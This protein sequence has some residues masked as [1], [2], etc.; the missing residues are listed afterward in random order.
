MIAATLIVRDEASQ[1]PEW[2]AYHHAIG[3]GKFVIY[4]HESRD[5]T[6]SVLR[7]SQARFDID[8]VSWPT[9]PGKVTQFFA[10]RDA[11]FRLRTQREVEWCAFIDIDEFLLSTTGNSV[12]ELADRCKHAAAI[13]L[14]WAV[15]GP[16]SHVTGHSQPDGLIIDQF[17]RRAPLQDA[18]NGPVKS[19]VRP[20]AVLDLLNPHAFLVDGQTV[21]GN[22][23]AFTF[24]AAENG[25][26]GPVEL[27]DWRV[28]HYASRGRWH[29]TRRLLRGQL[30]NEARD[31]TRWET[32][33]RN[34]EEDRSAP[35]YL[36]DAV[37]AALRE[38]NHP[39]SDYSILELD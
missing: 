11:C 39:K 17:I 2:L 28:N 15:F 8:V 12:Q 3:I 23:N 9:F 32:W 30:G 6:I 14:H 27:S 1:L 16:A 20:S 19:L 25:S 29:W 7:R 10:Y 24:N 34:E 5:D 36:A 22:G 13:T 33:N 21:D 18:V 35:Y 38:Q 37:H 4:N 26:A 31:E